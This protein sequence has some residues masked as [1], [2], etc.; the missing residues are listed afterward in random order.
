MQKVGE[1]LISIIEEIVQA[2][3]NNNKKAAVAAS[4]PKSTQLGRIHR[5]TPLTQQKPTLVD[6]L[7]HL[8]MAAEWSRHPFFP[9][10]LILLKFLK[11]AWKE[12][13]ILWELEEEK[14]RY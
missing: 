6:V 11:K 1:P 13:G 4:Q 14:F 9:I 2:I 3:E 10:V 7:H 5:K 12:V 8:R